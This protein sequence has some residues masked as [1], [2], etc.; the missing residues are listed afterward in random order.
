MNLGLVPLFRRLTVDPVER[1][2]GIAEEKMPTAFEA[3]PVKAKRLARH[4]IPVAL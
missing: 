2:T 1:M 3:L 4:S